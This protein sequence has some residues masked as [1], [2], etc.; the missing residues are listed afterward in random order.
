MMLL[1]SDQ[2]N[3]YIVGLKPE[4][5]KYVKNY[6]SSIVTCFDI[7]GKYLSSTN[8]DFLLAT[9]TEI[10]CN[11]R[12]VAQTQKAA[13]EIPTSLYLTKI[14]NL[15]LLISEVPKATKNKSKVT[16]YA[17]KIRDFFVNFFLNDLLDY[18]H[19][20]YS[21]EEVY[22]HNNRKKKL[23]A[24]HFD[25]IKSFVRTKTFLKFQTKIRKCNTPEEERFDRLLKYYSSDK[26]ISSSNVKK[27]SNEEE[28]EEDTREVLEI[29]QN[30]RHI[31]HDQLENMYF[32]E[33]NYL[34]AKH[35]NL[36][37]K[38]NIRYK[39]YRYTY[40]PKL[41]TSLTTTKNAIA[42]INWP[43]VIV[44]SSRIGFL[45]DI[46]NP[47]QYYTHENIKDA[48]WLACWIGT[49]WYHEN[50][51]KRIHIVQLLTQL[52]S[53]KFTVKQRELILSQIMDNLEVFGK[54]YISAE[55]LSYF[56]H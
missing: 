39:Y 52:P 1:T 40:I 43:P 32:M 35:S 41:L 11:Q 26:H 18:K 33:S 23:P 50:S 6:L 19:C 37:S 27:A 7:D 21:H 54:S 24:V 25:F 3:S 53:M 4:T 9:D 20:D 10:I 14:R 29:D 38:E 15:E 46:F 56:I 13:V 45:R 22:L 2:Q 51:E 44:R 8:K 48:I 17:N 28:E 55:N 36:S 30:L 42:K 5:Y 31:T 34:P 16:L 47:E 12:I 49:Y